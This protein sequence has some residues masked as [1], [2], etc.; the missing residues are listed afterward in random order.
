MNLSDRAN[1]RRLIRAIEIALTPEFSARHS[2]V[3]TTTIESR[4]YRSVSLRSRMTNYLMV[5]LTA[6]NDFLYS[7][8]DNWLDMRLKHGLVKEVQTLM[9]KHINKE[10]LENLG[11]EYR[12]IS[13]YLKGT[14]DLNQAVLRLKGD[15]H[16]Y[17]RRQKTYFRQFTGLNIQIFDISNNTWQNKLEKKVKSWYTEERMRN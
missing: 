11:L 15:I 6:P 3:A 8:S 9:K 12:W 2:G 4:S 13:R 5:G 7:R 10:W 17:I 1:P 14:T 16:S